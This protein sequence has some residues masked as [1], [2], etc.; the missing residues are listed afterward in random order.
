MSRT[1]IYPHED[2]PEVLEAMLAWSVKRMQETIEPGFA[3]FRADATA[4]GHAVDGRLVGVV[5]YDTF[6]TGD[7]LQHIVSDG[8]RRWMTRQF[9]VLALAYPFMQLNQRRITAL[10]SAD[11][12]DSIRL[13]EHFGFAREGTMRE[14]G[15][16][17]EDVHLFGLLRSECRWLTPRPR[18]AGPAETAL[19]VAVRDV[20][21]RRARHATIGG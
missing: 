14:A 1:Y 11:N 10:V 8:S 4:I 6:M 21:N 18:Y 19:S 20:A 5:I 9:M 2:H 13:S 3:R 17:G 12:R 15:A 16:R 7:C